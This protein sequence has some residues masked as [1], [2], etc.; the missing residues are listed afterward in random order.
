MQL[1]IEN[2][3]LIRHAQI[4]L[5]GLTVIAGTNDS[6]KSTIGKVIFSLV[7][8]I[9][10][11]QDDLEESK[12][13]QIEVVLREA[14]TV[15]RKRV[16]FSERPE[17]R[18]LFY[19]LFFMRDIRRHPDLA[20]QHRFQYVE[21]NV[22]YEWLLPD[23]ERVK[24]LIEQN[25][26]KNEAIHR[27]FI[28]VFYSEFSNEYRRLDAGVD[29]ESVLELKD[30]DNPLF[31]AEM[32][33]LNYSTRLYEDLI[34]LD[35]TLIETPYVLNVAE[36]LRMARAR[37]DEH[38]RHMPLLGRPNVALHIKDL[39]DK[40][41]EGGMWALDGDAFATDSAI[42]DLLS[43]ELKGEFSYDRESADFLFSD[44]KHS[45]KV[46]NIASGVK[47]FGVLQLL[48]KGGFLGK[49]QLV[50]VDE[51]E[52]HL[53]PKWQLLYAHIL[54]QLVER[55]A[56]V[57]VTTHS[58]YMLEALEIYSKQLHIKNVNYYYA[59]VDNGS[60]FTDVT[61]QLDRVYQSLA[62]PFSQL[63]R[64][65]LMPNGEFEW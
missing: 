37:F 13:H 6:G 33:D 8:A 43:K 65:R 18:E 30:G 57:L 38:Q 11:Y 60:V 28:K 48:E 9:Q 2:I 56:H 44:E 23:L 27:A 12:E 16:D 24:A 50:I 35:A 32:H 29:E 55:G 25:E 54:V 31:K 1:T 52:V 39:S 21:D 42:L 61:D 34:Y 17:L 22:E 62:E 3:G 58:P 53:H 19:P 15:L 26:D 41:R 64:E 49:G 46:L 36:P 10:R 14:Y 7:K 4:Q 40:L 5:N 59:S 63:E 45:Y 51:P 47:S 20:L